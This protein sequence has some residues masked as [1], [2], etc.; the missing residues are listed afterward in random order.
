MSNS[1]S[2]QEHKYL[3]CIEHMCI[4]KRNAKIAAEKYEHEQFTEME[5]SEC[6]KK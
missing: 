2:K 6:V 5:N 3:M 4:N 1:K